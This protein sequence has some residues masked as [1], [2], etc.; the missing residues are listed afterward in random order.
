MQSILYEKEPYFI[1]QATKTLSRVTEKLS[2]ACVARLAHQ[3]SPARRRAPQLASRGEPACATTPLSRFGLCVAARK[4]AA[5]SRRGR[6]FVLEQLLFLPRFLLRRTSSRTACASSAGG[7]AALLLLLRADRKAR[8]KKDI[9]S[10][11]GQMAAVRNRPCIYAI[12]S[13]SQ[14]GNWK[15]VRVL[16]WAVT[17]APGQRRQCTVA[18]RPQCCGPT[19]SR[20]MMYFP[21]VSGSATTTLRAA[22]SRFLH[23]RHLSHDLRVIESLPGVP[24]RPFPP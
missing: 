6:A 17:D 2:C 20:G 22:V 8:R 9:A 21:R 14:H 7:P 13:K 3:L 18:Q 10:Y 1:C 11:V 5:E 12:I 19:S 16:Y 15:S 24:E 23:H 4:L